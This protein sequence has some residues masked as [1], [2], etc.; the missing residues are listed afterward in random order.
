MNRVE[1]FLSLM[2]RYR[3]I[4]KVDFFGFLSKAFL[5]NPFHATGHDGQTPEAPG[6]RPAG[7]T[8]GCCLAKSRK[9]FWKAPVPVKTAR[10]FLPRR[11]LLPAYRPGVPCT[12]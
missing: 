1:R 5:L 7:K 4:P 10:L 8:A 3:P 12:V 6:C 9:P 11:L 2:N